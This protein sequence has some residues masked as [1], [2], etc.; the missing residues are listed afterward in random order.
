MEIVT[1]NSEGY[2]QEAGCSPYML[3]GHQQR[4]LAVNRVDNYLKC[5]A[6]NVN[7]NRCDLVCARHQQELSSAATESD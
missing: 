6:N 2:Q 4:Y 7:G 1:L 5:K 3:Q